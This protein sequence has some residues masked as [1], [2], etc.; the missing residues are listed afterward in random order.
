MVKN[1]PGF[2][3]PSGF[4]ASQHVEGTHHKYQLDEC[5]H[6]AN[7]APYKKLIDSI[8]EFAEDHQ[9]LMQRERWLANKTSF[10]GLVSGDAKL[11]TCDLE[12]GTQCFDGYMR[13]ANTH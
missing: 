11:Q 13:L 6:K 10:T 12:N 1:Q 8:W 2:C 7:Q 9:S 4:Q 3:W 5:R